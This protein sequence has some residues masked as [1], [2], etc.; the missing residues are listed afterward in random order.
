MLYHRVR[1]QKIDS[2]LFFPPDTDGHI[3]ED[4]MW[5]VEKSVMKMKEME[6][7]GAGWHE[8]EVKREKADTLCKDDDEFK[9]WPSNLFSHILNILLP[10]RWAV[11]IS[12]DYLPLLHTCSP[13]RPLM[14]CLQRKNCHLPFYFSLRKVTNLHSTMARLRHCWVSTLEYFV[15][16]VYWFWLIPLLLCRAHEQKVWGGMGS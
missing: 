8:I 3:R 10:P 15:V 5:R 16:C 7:S 1:V 9:V 11:L 14:S 13:S 4:R 12:W 6:E 2:L